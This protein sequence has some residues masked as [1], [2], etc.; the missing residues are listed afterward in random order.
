MV[1]SLISL[2]VVCL[3]DTKLGD[4]DFV[5]AHYQDYLSSYSSSQA[6]LAA[7]ADAELAARQLEVFGTNDIGTTVAMMAADPS[8]VSDGAWGFS[9]A[10]LALLAM[11]T[12]ADPVAEAAYQVAYYYSREQKARCDQALVSD[13]RDPMTWTEDQRLDYYTVLV[14]TQW[15]L[16]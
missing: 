6:A 4:R 10:G 14:Y 1:R 5:L 15:A 11:Q 8:L 16:S 12:A 9:H 13:V 7:Q 2:N 3:T